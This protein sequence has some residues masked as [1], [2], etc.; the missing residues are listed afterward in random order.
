[1]IVRHLLWSPAMNLKRLGRNWQ[2]LGETDP[3]WAILTDATHKGRRWD[4]DEFYATGVR[5]VEMLLDRFEKWHV[6]RERRRA[7][8][9][10]C[11]A[12]RIT[13]PLATHFDEY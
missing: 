10:G 4:E 6:P 11:G 13:I 5:E 2:H 3:H 12:G 1:M 7:L 9:F 8:D